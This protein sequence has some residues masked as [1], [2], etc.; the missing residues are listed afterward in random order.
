MESREAA[1]EASQAT[2]GV[3]RAGR[4]SKSTRGYNN[5]KE[6]NLAG[7]KAPAGQ[8]P[9]A[10]SKRVRGSTGHY[11]TCGKCKRTGHLLMCDGCDEAYH[12][13]CTKLTTHPRLDENFYCGTCMERG[14]NVNSDA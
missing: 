10:S 12:F 9:R 14:R 11:D 1:Q 7:R 2:L 8:R 4:V 6:M 3:S 13:K 5:F